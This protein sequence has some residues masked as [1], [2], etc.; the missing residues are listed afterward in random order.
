[1]S[2]PTPP[3]RPITPVAPVTPTGPGVP[4]P[5]YY[6]DPSIPGY[7]RYWNGAAWVP[8]TSRP[9]PEGGL[10]PVA[11]V[12]PPGHAAALAP[13]VAGPPPPAA[14]VAEETGP[15]FFDELPTGEQPAAWQ[16]IPTQQ[17]APAVRQTESGGVR[18]LNRA[19]RGL[20]PAPAQPQAEPKPQPDEARTPDPAA[21][22]RP[23]TRPRESRTAKAAAEAAAV[24]ADLAARSAQPAPER[25][26]ERRRPTP[27]PAQAPA[28]DQA[29]PPAQAPLPA[30]PPQAGE[31]PVTERGAKRP[32]R[33]RPAAPAPLGAR[34]AARLIDL[35]VTA[36]LSLPLAL[37]LALRSA[38]HLDRKIE[39]ARDSGRTV[40][41]WLIDGTTGPY[42]ALFATVLLLFGLLY[43]AL[44]TATWGRTLGKKLC[45]LRVVDV[46][47]QRPPSLTAAG[48]RWLTMFLTCLP[49]VGLAGLLRGLYDRPR[50]QCWHDRA[51]GTYVAR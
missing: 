33:P 30:V 45:G 42:L 41:V 21:P 3:A 27:S 36:A 44:P 17:D 50:R 48:K 14:P 37:P 10:P 2:A 8:G 40:H 35:V 43:E 49:L 20:A 4:G 23:A 13:S 26:T 51:A 38:E 22:A 25:A 19:D 9:L 47:T 12:P 15:V 6:P 1:M 24:A 11:A 28:G 29:Q 5:G 7:I 39:A 31:R 18:I 34:L 16:P 32:A 46:R